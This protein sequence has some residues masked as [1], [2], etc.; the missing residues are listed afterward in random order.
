[1]DKGG[2]FAAW[3]EPELFAADAGGVPIP[4]LA[5]LV[6]ALLTTSEGQRLATWVCN[7]GKRPRVIF[8][9]NGHGDHWRPWMRWP[10]PGRTTR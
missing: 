5:V 6:D 10:R 2:H 4:A 8:V 9:T 7:A 1:M 3:E